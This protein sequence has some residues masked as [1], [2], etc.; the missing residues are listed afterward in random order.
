MLI[1]PKH[2]G[3][4]EEVLIGEYK[5]LLPT[6]PNLKL[7]GN[8]DL[9]K[10]KQKFIPT[11]LPPDIMQWDKKSRDEFEDNEWKKRNN[12]YW[13]WNNGELQ[14]LTGTNYFYINWWKIDIG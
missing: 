1:L 7:I 3:F 6:P 5:I 11:P 8:K 9:P 10:E 12:G 4:K 2:S 14:W 13:F